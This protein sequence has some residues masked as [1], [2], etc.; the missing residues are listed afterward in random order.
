MSRIAAFAAA[1]SLSCLAGSAATH[2]Q[3]PQKVPRIGVLVNGSAPDNAA[4]ASLRAGLAR[5]GYVEGKDVIIEDRYADGK[6]DRMPALAADLVGANVDVIA[7]Y[8]GPASNAAFKATRTIPIV[9]AIVADP[10]A[11]GFAATLE[12]PGGNATGL[13]NNDPQ[14]ARLQLSMLKEILPRLERVA[15][16]SDQDIPGADASGL[17]PIERTAVAAAKGLGL[18]PHV[19]K[20][21]GPAPD[22]EAAFRTISE[23]R[24]DAVLVLEVPV[25]LNHRKRI[26]E[27]ATAQKLPSMCP[28]AYADTGGLVSYGTSVADTWPGVPLYVDKILKGAGPGDLP[29]QVIDRRYLIVNTRTARDLGLAIPADLLKRADKVIE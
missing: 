11:L 17:A 13:T 8:G 2:A 12:H 29:V 4:T 6:L 21:R 3:Q 9:Y 20:L 19:L 25:T 28:A 14:Q 5:L 27:M 24:D 26:A 18:Q 1:L 10:V 23:E 7:T 22:I 15:I 16:L